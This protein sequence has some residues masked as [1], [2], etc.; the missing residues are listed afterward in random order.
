MHPG[1]PVPGFR[2]DINGLRAWAVIVVLFFHFK[3][4]GFSAGFIGVDI[5]FVISGFLMTGIILRGLEQGKF[6]LWLF[7]MARARRIIPALLLLLVVLLVLG[8]FW[9]STAD[10]RQLG[11]QS[12]YALSFISNI[13]YWQSAGYFDSAAHEKW[14]LHTWSLGVEMQFYL[15]YPLF[16]LFMWKIWPGIKAFTWGL[17]AVGLLSFLLSLGISSSKPVAAFYLLPTRG[18]ELAA[19]GIVYLLGRR[20]SQPWQ[21]YH[22]T[23]Y[24]AGLL[25]WLIGFILIDGHRAW[26]SGWALLPVLGTALIILSCQHY[27]RLL[28]NPLAQ[29]LGNISYSLYL[30]H[31]PLV[32]ALYFIGLQQ[33]W[34]WV[35][36]GLMLSLLLGH[37]SLKLVENPVRRSLAVATMGKQVAILSAA[38]LIIG[39]GAIGIRTLELPTRPPEKYALATAESTNYELRSRGECAPTSNNTSPGCIYGPDDIGAILIGDSHAQSNITALEQAGATHGKG[40][41]YLASS[42]CRP[43]RGLRSS[44]ETSCHLYNEWLLDDELPKYAGSGIPVIHITRLSWLFKGYNE[45]PSLK[46][47][48]YIDTLVETF[49]DPGANQRFRDAF[50]ETACSIAAHNPLYVLRPIPE[51]GVNVPSTL[52]SNIRFRNSDRDIRIPLGEYHERHAY[53]MDMLNEAVEKCGIKILDPLPYLC[54][55]KYCYGSRNGRPLYYDDD[56]LSEFGNKYLVPLFD[57]VFQP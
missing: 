50:I 41:L 31:W 17:L 25:L 53:T 16:V 20:S 49:D 46:Q 54:D 52:A 11:S 18:W 6:S 57:Q 43:I 33:Q 21:Q 4:P 44:V 15:L 22:R 48:D 12:A 47:S 3:I 5:F 1:K 19:G 27:S 9:L 8:W 55:E 56:H 34:P 42:G 14:L 30:W 40:T 51:M 38:G 26:P 29:W 32:V 23:L 24:F 13:Q 37:L 45:D 2:T 7:Y 39:C 10:Y 36:G 28:N 35:A